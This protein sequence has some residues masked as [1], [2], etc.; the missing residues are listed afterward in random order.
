MRTG[1]RP[2]RG[3][4]YLTAHLSLVFCRQ[5]NFVTRPGC[6]EQ[7]SAVTS[8]VLTVSGTATCV[9]SRSEYLYPRD[10]QRQCSAFMVIIH[11][12]AFRVSACS[13]RCCSAFSVQQSVFSVGVQQSNSTWRNIQKLH[14]RSR[15][16]L[17][18][19]RCKHNHLNAASSSIQ[20]YRAGST[21][22]CWVMAP[23][24][25]TFPGP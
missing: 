13:N 11:V 1:Q 20:W 10:W 12:P 17:N 6:A 4:Q 8:N 15:Q 3:G 21:M 25:S 18:A 19:S 22:S 24:R 5:V 9:K 2:H 14:Q 23:Q 7:Q 16:A